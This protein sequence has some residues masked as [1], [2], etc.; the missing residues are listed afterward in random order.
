MDGTKRCQAKLRTHIHRQTYTDLLVRHFSLVCV[1][2]WSFQGDFN[3]YYCFPLMLGN[4]SSIFCYISFF[5]SLSVPYSLSTIFFL[6]PISEADWYFSRLFFLCLSICFWSLT[7]LTFI[8]VFFPISFHWH[9][10]L[11]LSLHP[12]ILLSTYPILIYDDKSVRFTKSSALDSYI[13]QKHNIIFSMENFTLD[14]H[15]IL[16]EDI[17]KVLLN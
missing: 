8:A 9:N 13:Q 16:L 5:L 4:V 17:F 2:V 11:L 3:I 10:P 6:Y 15:S 14:V 1:R 12:C 7:P